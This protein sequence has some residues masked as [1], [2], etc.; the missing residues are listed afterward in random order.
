MSGSWPQG[1]LFVRVAGYQVQYIGIIF[2]A[3]V[4]CWWYAEYN[5]IT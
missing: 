3:N 5:V 2:P 1:T 4:G